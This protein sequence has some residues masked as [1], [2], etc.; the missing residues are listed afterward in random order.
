KTHFCR[1]VVVNWHKN[2]N[3]IIRIMMGFNQ[4][5]MAYGGK[6]LFTDV[7]LLLSPR[8]RYALVGA[9]GTGKSTLLRLIAGEEEALSGTVSVS[10]DL[11]IGWLKQ[12]QYRYE[13]TIITDIVIQGKLQLWQA[14]KEKE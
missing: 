12:D 5:S 4:L 10:K 6:L 7:N 1:H 9:N 14:L 13:E 8:T 3:R 11:S 2:V